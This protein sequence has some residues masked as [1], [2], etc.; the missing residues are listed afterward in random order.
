VA[1]VTNLFCDPDSTD[2]VVDEIWR[3]LKPGGKVLAVLPAVLIV[4][5]LTVLDL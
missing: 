4:Q 2:A 3:V 5:G 1:C